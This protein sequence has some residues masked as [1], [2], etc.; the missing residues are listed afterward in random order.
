MS[1]DQIEADIAKSE[2]I[3]M[4]KDP[5]E[6]AKEKLRAEQETVH[7]DPDKPY[8]DIK[9]PATGVVGK[10]CNIK[11]SEKVPFAQVAISQRI[12]WKK[13]DKYD[14]KAKPEMVCTAFFIQDYEDVK[15]IKVT[16]EDIGY[17]KEKAVNNLMAGEYLV[18]AR[19][20]T[21][22]AYEET[23]AKRLVQ[24]SKDG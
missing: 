10:T 13:R 12:E 9:I 14:L 8:V 1:E 6:K 7:E 5:L 4:K 11:F 23:N 21:K 15:E 20:Y 3:E 16:W 17:F 22:Q 24:V 2:E 19:A 18:E